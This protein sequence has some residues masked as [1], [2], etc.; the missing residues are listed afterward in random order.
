MKTI[1]GDEEKGMN[2]T[3]YEIQKEGERAS[4]S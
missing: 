4:S 3:G 2:V 1:G